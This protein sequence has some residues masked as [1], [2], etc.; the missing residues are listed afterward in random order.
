MFVL[1]SKR[2]V[3]EGDH[4]EENDDDVATDRAI[5]LEL[6][7]RET[8]FPVTTIPPSR[9]DSTDWPDDEI[10]HDI[11]DVLS[12]A[13]SLSTA[14]STLHQDDD[15]DDDSTNVVTMRPS[16]H[17]IM[18]QKV[19]LLPARQ[20]GKTR[21]GRNKDL[22]QQQNASKTKQPK[23]K[24]II[25]YDME[26]ASAGDS[27]IDDRSEASTASVQSQSSCQYLFKAV[28]GGAVDCS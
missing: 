11:T 19:P 28:R 8:V 4:Q 15:D 22:P 18:V 21:S 20:R 23:K 9:C 10:P 16:A 12:L 14:E 25:K 13:D 24:M 6:T 17:E 1:E 26:E 5:R 3:D 2:T 27:E 7:N